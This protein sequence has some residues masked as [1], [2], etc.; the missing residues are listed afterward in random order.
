[1]RRIHR[2]LPAVS[3]VGVLCPGLVP[4]YVLS[5]CKPVLLASLKCQTSLQLRSA[6]PTNH[7]CTTIRGLGQLAAGPSQYGAR[8]PSFGLE[9]RRGMSSHAAGS[10]EPGAGRAQVEVE[11]K[12][13]LSEGAEERVAA[14]LPF[15]V[16]RCTNQQ[17][18]CSSDS[19]QQGRRARAAVLTLRD[20]GGG[21]HDG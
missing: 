8:Y 12:F 18:S 7:Q 6:V 11:K 17:A 3:L 21:E 13:M 20:A 5:A 14:V 4:A 19:M 16:S 10:A 15:K 1:M 9:T 2:I